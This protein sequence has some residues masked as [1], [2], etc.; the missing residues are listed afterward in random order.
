MSIP[1][2]L[3]LAALGGGGT[4][5]VIEYALDYAGLKQNAQSTFRDDLL[6]RVESLRGRVSRLEEDLERERK[7][8]LRAELKNEILARRI[9]LLVDELNRLREREGMEPLSAEEFQVSEPF[10]EDETPHD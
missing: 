10:N 8:R 2:Q 4:W 7:A 3:L 5:K 6:E 1:L 9:Q